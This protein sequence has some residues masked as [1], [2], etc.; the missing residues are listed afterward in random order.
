MD[1]T[2]KE[3]CAGWGGGEDFTFTLC[4][5]ACI[6]GEREADMQGD[7]EII[8]TSGLPTTKA[9]GLEGGKHEKFLAKV[10]PFSAIKHKLAKFHTC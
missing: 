3:G 2:L 7:T 10:S 6:G 4:C 9:L 5:H 8:G 1:V